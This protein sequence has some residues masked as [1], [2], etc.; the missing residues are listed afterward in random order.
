MP[1]VIVHSSQ[2]KRAATI[3]ATATVRGDND[4]VAVVHRR[5]CD[6]LRGEDDM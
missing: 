1:L 2:A 3:T 5:S 4:V 6:W